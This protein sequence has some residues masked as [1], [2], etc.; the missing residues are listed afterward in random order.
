M[1]CQKFVIFRTSNPC[2]S[3]NNY[4]DR[5]LCKDDFFSHI[6]EFYKIFSSGGTKLEYP[7]Y[8]KRVPVSSTH[9]KNLNR[10]KQKRFSSQIVEL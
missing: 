5:P 7:M 10:D 4:K 8:T 1:S 3:H 9:P 6:R 2:S